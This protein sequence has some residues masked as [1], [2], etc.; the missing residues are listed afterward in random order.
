MNEQTA[1]KITDPH[2]V[3]VTFVNEI[4][5]MGFLNGILN[6]TFTVARFTPEGT[7]IVPDMVIASRLRMDLQCAQQLHQMMGQIIE[8]NTKPKSG[9]N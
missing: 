3:A 9:L 5:N 1:L 4:G 8:Q 6:V 7:Q 2:N